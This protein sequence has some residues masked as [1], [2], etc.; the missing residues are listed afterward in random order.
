MRCVD[1]ELSTKIDLSIQPRTR[2]RR[3]M[4]WCL[5]VANLV[6]LEE[7]CSVNRDLSEGIKF[8]IQQRGLIRLRLAVAE[9]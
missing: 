3:R 5:A 6:K 7:L 8:A 9:A 4:T 2:I 1:L